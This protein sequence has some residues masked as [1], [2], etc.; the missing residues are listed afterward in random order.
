MIALI[1]GDSLLYKV[2]FAIEEDIDWEGDN[3]P[4]YYSN[5]KQQ[6]EAI[7]GMVE[8][9]LLATGCDSYCLYLTGNHNF[10]ENIPISYKENRLNM[11]KPTDFDKLKKWLLSKESTYLVE[12]VEADDVVVYLK[13]RYPDKYVL[14]AI[15][16]DVLYQ[17]TGNH[18][19]Y[20]KDTMIT[21]TEKEAIWFAYYQTLVGDVTDGYKGCKGVGDK[22][23]RQLLPTN[24]K[25]EREL[26]LQV[27][28]AYRKAGMKRSEAIA[29]M[30]IANMRQYNG[31]EVVLW[32]PPKK[33]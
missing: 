26:W 5:L 4:S 24:Y 27:L 33:S 14:C 13:N 8:S 2:G 18:Y 20:N 15:D 7:E 28:L 17:A 19:N 3:N 22:K 1:D 29:T 12:G 11:R 32:Q 25:N 30:R 23:A 6:Q 21:V 9:M 10:R 31:I 16:K